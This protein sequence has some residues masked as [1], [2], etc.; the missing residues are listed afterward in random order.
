MADT[1]F[2][3]GPYRVGADME[4]ICLS[5]GTSD[6]Y[7]SNGWAKKLAT[8]HWKQSWMTAEES[9]A[10]ANLFAAAP[11]LYVMLAQTAEYFSDADG[12]EEDE[13]IYRQNVRAALA[14]ARGE[15]A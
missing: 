4:S 12:L 14:K 13:Y 1:K 15:A 6:D 3:P 10:N 2:T 9:L 5:R 8:V 7:T 11:E